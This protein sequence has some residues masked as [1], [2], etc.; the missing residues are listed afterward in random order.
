[1]IWVLRR[2]IAAERAKRICITNAR[3]HTDWMRDRV[4]ALRSH[5]PKSMLTRNLTVTMR[6]CMHRYTS[7]VNK[8][9]Q[10]HKHIHN[11]T[12][13]YMHTCINT[14]AIAHLHTFIHTC[15]H[16]ARDFVPRTRFQ[17]SRHTT[18]NTTAH[19]PQRRCL[20]KR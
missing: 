16:D 15:I 9:A 4:Q 8:H 17:I 18:Q 13:I 1:M 7:S 2:S 12:R 20:C 10:M 11:S 6:I 5:R 14:F 19:K 3:E